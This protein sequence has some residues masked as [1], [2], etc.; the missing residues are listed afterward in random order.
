MSAYARTLERLGLRYLIL[1]T[2][3]IGVKEP[4]DPP[5]TFDRLPADKLRISQCHLREIKPRLAREFRSLPEEDLL[6]SSFVF[7]AHLTCGKLPAS[8]GA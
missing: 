8:E 6:V 7:S 4:V 1:V 2:G 5:L 3:L